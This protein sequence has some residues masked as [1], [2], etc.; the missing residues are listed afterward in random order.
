MCYSGCF[1]ENF[2]GDCTARDVYSSWIKHGKIPHCCNPLEDLINNLR[3]E[4]NMKI[5]NK[6]HKLKHSKMLIDLDTYEKICAK[7]NLP[8]EQHLK[9]IE[10]MQYDSDFVPSMEDVSIMMDVYS[11]I[12]KI[13]RKRR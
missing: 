11:Y 13:I 8:L 12:T 2:Y 1:Y 4:D 10:K 9:N 3:K 6:N 5:L 7:Y